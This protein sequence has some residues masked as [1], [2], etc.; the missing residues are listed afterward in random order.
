MIKS[1]G[2]MK[3]KRGLT[4]EQ[5]LHHWEKVHAPVFLAKNVPG[6]RRYVQN[7]RVNVEGP[8]FESDI[9]GIAELW[10]D[11]VESLVAFYRWHNSS[12]EAEDLR[13][14]S[15]LYVDVEE[16]KPLFLAEEHVLKE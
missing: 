1:F 15:K 3:R 4:L 16:L 9:D 7:H 10:F 12:P 5:F 11:D 13:E 14:D 6:F 2:I 8:G